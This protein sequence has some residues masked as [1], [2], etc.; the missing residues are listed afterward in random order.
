M[1]GRHSGSQALHPKGLKKPEE[2][3][4]KCLLTF[5]LWSVG[6]RGR[7]GRTQSLD[8]EKRL[9]IRDGDCKSK[10]FLS[11]GPRNGFVVRRCSW[12]VPAP[13]GF[14]GVPPY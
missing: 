9:T 11:S 2:E 7:P 12:S 5:Q 3:L 14:F 6:Q 8:E 4:H 10:P 13:R 1:A